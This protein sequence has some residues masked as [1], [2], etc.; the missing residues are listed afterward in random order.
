MR[1]IAR[2]IIDLQRMMEYKHQYVVDV[3]FGEP[4]GLVISTATTKSAS[5]LRLKYDQSA[6]LNN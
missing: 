1:R 3:S 5:D 6:R 2:I 4:Q